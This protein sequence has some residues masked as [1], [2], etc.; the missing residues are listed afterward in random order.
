M[1]KTD[2]NVFGAKKSSIEYWAN[3]R[4]R[5]SELYP[6]ERHFLGNCLENITTVLDVGC[7]AGGGA[8]F[9]TEI[10]SKV[11]YTGIDICGN[12][13]V[14]ARKKYN[15][16]GSFYQYDGKNI[17]FGNKCFDLIFSFGVIHYLIHWKN[18]VAQMVENSKRFTLFDLRLTEEETFSDPEI[19]YQKIAYNEKWDGTT[20]VP[21]IV[22][23]IEEALN[24]LKGLLGEGDRVESCG[25]YSSPTSLAITPL[26]KVLTMSFLFEKDAEEPGCY[27]E[28]T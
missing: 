21:Y 6:S 18:I 12:L 7:A 2:K 11:N 16:I 4:N 17:P 22:L 13:I 15:S 26:D 5:F 10:N 20:K 3:N 23:N 28:I 24:Y 27:F 25:Y 19:S 14:Q 8:S 1:N 9:C